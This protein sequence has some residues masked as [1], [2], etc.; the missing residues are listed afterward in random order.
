MA[1]E[2]TKMAVRSNVHMNT[3]VVEVIELNSE[4]RC[5]LPGCLEAAMASE[6]TK[7]AVR[8]NMHMDTRV[9]KVAGLKLE[10]AKALEATT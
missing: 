5:D 2:A 1:I 9:F 3:R 8:G 4:V 10:A 6:V 7:M